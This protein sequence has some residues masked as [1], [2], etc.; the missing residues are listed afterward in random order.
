MRLP[1]ILTLLVSLTTACTTLTDEARPRVQLAGLQM[2]DATLMEQRFLARVR[3]QNRDRRPLEVEGLTFDLELN[4][5][6]FASGVSHRKLVLD[7]LSEGVVEVTL[8]STLFGLIRQIQALQ[9]QQEAPFRY[10]FRGTLYVAGRIAGIPFSEE[11]EM[12]L[13]RAASQGHLVPDSGH[14]SRINDPPSSRADR[15]VP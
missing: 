4:G 3:I 13:D 9:A 8:T 2:L 5:Q 1:V 10:A 14:S 15:P 6:P 11:G 12:A 7:G